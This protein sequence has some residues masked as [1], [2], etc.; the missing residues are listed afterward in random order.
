LP[1]GLLATTGCQAI[2]GTSMKHVE[3]AR[4]Q[5]VRQTF[6]APLVICRQAALDAAQA[7]SMLL[8]VNDLPNQ[9][10]MLLHVPG[11]IDT[12]EVGVFFTPAA[13]AQTTVEIAS[14]SLE[15]RDT[16]ARL[17]FPALEKLFPAAAATATP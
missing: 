8:F 10:L 2:L 15:A 3:K 13:P 5:A 6:P 1:L 17:L 12:T 9:R 11:S 16:V 14:H 4:S 7:E